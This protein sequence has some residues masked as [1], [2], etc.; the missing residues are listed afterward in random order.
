MPGGNE[1]KRA[2]AEALKV[3]MR[4]T[5]FSRVT[6]DG[7]CE[8]A[9]V[10][11]RNFYR[12][13]PDKY[14]LLNWLYYDDFCAPLHEKNIQRSIDLIPHVCAHLYEDRAFFL[15][16]FDVKGQNSFRDFCKGRLYCYLE[17]DY[18]QAFPS[19]EME[20]FYIE[21]ILDALFD[22]FQ[23]WLKSEPC[24]PPQEFSDYLISSLT[25]FSVRFT[26][27]ALQQPEQRPEK[28]KKDI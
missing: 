10:S 3:L 14:E 26:E 9:Y 23:I 17:R 8:Q 5:P 19:K 13:F 27:V 21:H 12:Y 20:R 16:A 7:I 25:R 2:L 18:G 11:R 24:M 22:G 15:N 4:K 6:V 1:T 28:A